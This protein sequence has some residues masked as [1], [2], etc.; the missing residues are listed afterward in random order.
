M[1][2]NVDIE[3]LIAHTVATTVAEV[4][5][6]MAG[7]RPDALLAETATTDLAAA[8]TWV[9]VTVSPAVAVSRGWHFLAF[10]PLTASKPNLRILNGSYRGMGWGVYGAVEP[11]NTAHEGTGWLTSATGLSALP[12]PAGAV[13]IGGY[14]LTTMAAKIWL[15]MAA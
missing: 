9:P 13:V 3:A 6:Q 1:A 5:R 10:M 15:R 4:M 8:S 7:G 2:D 11:S 12:N 14:S